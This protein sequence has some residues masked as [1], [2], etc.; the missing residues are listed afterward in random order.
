MKRR[1][2]LAASTL[3]ALALTRCRGAGPA[4]LDG[5]STDDTTPGDASE[6]LDAAPPVD[7]FA[8]L[9]EARE[10][11]AYGVW[12]G[13]AQ[14]DRAVFAT[15]Y[16]G[17]SALSLRVQ[18]LGATSIVRVAYDARVEPDGDGYVYAP[19]SGL[20]PGARHT[21]AFV[22]RDRD[23]GEPLRRSAV[24]SLR[25]A[26]DGG[27]REPLRFLAVSCTKAL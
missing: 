21:Y 3:G 13:D 16:T 17:P 20:T 10:G 14:R 27:S 19:V 23:R 8:T 5:A 6:A 18:E 7:L 1:S 12:A 2:F 15:R 9:D 22:E 26:F 24:G 25:A 4:A 11:F